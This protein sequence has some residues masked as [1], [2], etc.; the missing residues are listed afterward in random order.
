VIAMAYLTNPKT[1]TFGKFLNELKNSDALGNVD[2]MDITKD[3]SVFFKKA[4]EVVK[5]AQLE[6]FY[7][8]DLSEN[9]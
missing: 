2:F 7:S 4:E 8:Q 1:K 6:D 9:I 5:N 3:P